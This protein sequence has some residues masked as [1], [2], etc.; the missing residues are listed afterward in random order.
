MSTSTPPNSAGG[1]DPSPGGGDPL[2]GFGYGI[3]LSVAFII[4]FVIIT[5]ISYVCKRI[6]VGTA[7]LDHRGSI[8]RG[9]T[10]RGPSN[11][12]LTIN[13]G[14][15][16]LDEDTLASYPRFA[17]SEVRAHKGGSEDSAC[18]I[19]LADY[20]DADL[21]RLLPDCRHLFHL[22][23]IDPWLVLHSTCPVCRKSPLPTPLA[24]AAQI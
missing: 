2:G 24:P 3:G 5:Y 8:N 21:V 20:K 1:S 7:G 9:L 17:Y 14:H 4:M 18:A 13:N 16:G 15:D 22:V 11:V 6:H 19:C 12:V 23:C 10:Y